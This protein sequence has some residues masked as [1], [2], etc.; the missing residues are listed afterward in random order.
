MGTP[1]DAM[2]IALA[3]H[4]ALVRDAIE[5]HGGY[6][7]KTVGDA[8]CSAFG[9]A[10]TALAAARA[11]QQALSARRFFE[12][13]WAAVRMAVHTGPWKNETETTS[14]SAVDRAARL[15]A[16]GHGGQVLV[17]QAAADLVQ[18]SLPRKTICAIS[19]HIG[20]RI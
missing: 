4:N 12:R 1:P 9:M 6:V 10:T 2:G 17:S 13:R 3:R 7:F 14:G 5:A 19:A 16:I 18:D 11:A 20:L 15:L 8:F